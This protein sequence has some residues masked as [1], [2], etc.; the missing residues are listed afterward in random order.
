MT[1]QECTLSS[2]EQLLLSASEDKTLMLW[3]TS[4]GECKC[5][6]KGHREPVLSCAISRD[7][8]YVWPRCQ[9]RGEIDHRHSF[10][11]PCFSR[12]Y[13]FSA[14][15]DH[16][17]RAWDLATGRCRETLAG[18]SKAVLHVAAGPGHHLISSS[19]D[20]S[21]KVGLRAR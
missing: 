20:Q 10:V 11:W 18:H 4:S 1:Q 8:L 19:R 7:G 5:T 16:T 12:R 3:D 13:A 15:D 6:L 2:D 9:W 21:I 14:S 17:I